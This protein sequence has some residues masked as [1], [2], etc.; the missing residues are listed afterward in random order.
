MKFFSLLLTQP[1]KQCLQYLFPCFNGV[2]HV[3]EPFSDSTDTVQMQLWNISSHNLSSC[4][5]TS[6]SNIT[7]SSIQ[8]QLA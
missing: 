1:V 7:N 6:L 5:A 8:T 4:E 2:A 3:S